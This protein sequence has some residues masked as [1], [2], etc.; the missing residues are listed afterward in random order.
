M[1]G[2]HRGSMDPPLRLVGDPVQY[3]GTEWEHQAAILARLRSLICCAPIF[4]HDELVKYVSRVFYYS[5]ETRM[6]N[7]NLV[8]IR[9]LR[10]E[11]QNPC[12]LLYTLYS[13]FSQPI[14]LRV[15]NWTVFKDGFASSE[16]SNPVQKAS[17]GRFSIAPKNELASQSLLPAVPQVL[18]Y[19][20]AS[21][22]TFLGTTCA[23][24]DFV[25]LF[26]VIDTCM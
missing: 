12:L 11:L 4:P 14:C 2:N 16:V 6:L 24:T 10:G 7:A 5:R 22:C 9:S 21:T 15:S 18:L 3:L 25:F 17:D 1:A 19:Y 23:L 26:F 20:P 8:L 13:T